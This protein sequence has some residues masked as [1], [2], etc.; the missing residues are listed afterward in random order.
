MPH[1]LSDQESGRSSGFADHGRVERDVDAWMRP[2]VAD[3]LAELG[4][5]VAIDSGSANA[6]G[7]DRVGDLVAGRLSRLGFAVERRPTVTFGSAV[8][9]R[10]S[11]RG[12]VRTMLLGHLD[13]VYPDGTAAERPLRV[14]GDHVTGPGVSDMKGGILAALY[15]VEAL[16]EHGL[17]PFAELVVVCTPDEEHA[18]QECQP[19]LVELGRT[20]DV[21]LCLESGRANGDIVCERKAGYVWRLDVHGRS[22]HAG[23]EPE[24]GASAIVELA[25][26]V[27]GLQALA[28]P[29]VG[30]TINVGLVAGGTA[31]NAVASHATATFEARA[32]TAGE[33]ARVED[34]IAALL[35][36]TVVPGVT[37]EL[38][39]L[40]RCPPMERTADVVHLVELARAGAASLGWSLGAASTGGGSDASFVAAAGI[41]VLDGLGPV[42]GLDH[43]PDEYLDLASVAPRVALLAGLIERI[44]RAGPRAAVVR[45]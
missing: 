42:G 25:H 7:V 20:V 40:V 18:E 12:T 17:E 44:D 19:L 33:L 45:A 15:A 39:P 5:W 22:A 29:A 43:G 11:G 36:T 27:V 4:E 24:K 23:V 31:S 21:A 34:G 38:S 35:A 26:K 1:E 9:G 6:A 41:P 8:V 14:E 32:R 2:R 30:T 16:V 3:F 28:D 10:R 37:A 13:T